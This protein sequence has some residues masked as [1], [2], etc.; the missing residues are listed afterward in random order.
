MWSSAPDRVS[1]SDQWC[2][3]TTSR[4]LLVSGS[5][6]QDGCILH[7]RSWQPVAYR[8]PYNGR[9]SRRRTWLHH[10]DCIRCRP[11]APRCDDRVA[12]THQIS[13]C[14]AATIAPQPRVIACTQS[15]RSQVIRVSVRQ[16]LALS[17]R[18]R[19]PGRRPLSGGN[20]KG[21]RSRQIDANDPGR[22]KSRA[23]Q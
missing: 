22:V 2:E 12:P 14:A 11:S 17:R 7:L 19:S 23:L 13:C 6:S 1:G 5:T 10:R 4:S 9:T 15:T 16:L 18:S 8:K 3:A 20:R 21:A